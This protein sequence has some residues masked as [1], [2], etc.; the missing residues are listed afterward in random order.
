VTSKPGTKTDSVSEAALRENVLAA[1]SRLSRRALRA[2][3]FYSRSHGHPAVGK[4]FDDAEMSLLVE[5][6]LDFWLT[7]GRFAE[8]FERDFARRL[9]LP[10]ALLVNSGSSANLLAVSTLTAPELGARR[11][12]PAT[13]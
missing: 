1:V 6:G 5:S 13:R 12:K 11:L 7:T 4:V 10:H 2:A 3:P 8:R 9:G